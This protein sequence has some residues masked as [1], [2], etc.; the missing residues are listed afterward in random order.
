MIL[1]RLRSN[2]LLLLHRL[3]GN[4]SFD[5]TSN[6]VTGSLNVAINRG[7]ATAIADYS[8]TPGITAGIAVNNISVANS[9]ITFTTNSTNNAG[10]FQYIL[11][12]L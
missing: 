2:G 9:S 5:G 11:I 4:L 12:A 8:T 7:L 1:L 6:T 3:W 10:G